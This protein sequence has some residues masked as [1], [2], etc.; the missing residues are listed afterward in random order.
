MNGPALDDARTKKRFLEVLPL[1]I[2]NLQDELTKIEALHS[3]L[4][5]EREILRGGSP[6]ALF[7]SNDEKERI[8]AELA[9]IRS[10]RA[11]IMMELSD[12]SGIPS[13]QVTV[14]MLASLASGPVR[15]DLTTLRQR[16]GPLAD[17][18]RALNI[19]NRG[20]IENSRRYVK[21]WLTFLLNAAA[22][23]PC[24]AKSGAVPQAGIKG[25]F[26]RTE[27]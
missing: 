9:A 14:S 4:T 3:C 23:A 18:I 20:L 16:F 17:E 15:R 26:F 12:L 2:S 24:Y 22:S 1:L 25:R 21:N 5:R 10:L 8:F 6:Q 13:D 7:G 19:R 27:G 11:P